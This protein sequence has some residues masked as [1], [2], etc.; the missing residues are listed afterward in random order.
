MKLSKDTSIKKYEFYKRLAYYS[1]VFIL[2][3]AILIY[4][5]IVDYEKSGDKFILECMQAGK[6]YEFCKNQWY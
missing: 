5:L 6:S 3:F 2:F 1:V 4:M